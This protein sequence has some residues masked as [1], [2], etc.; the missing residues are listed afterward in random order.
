MA[1]TFAEVYGVRADAE[2]VVS[3]P[4]FGNLD[5]G[6]TPFEV[7]ELDGAAERETR[8]DEAAVSAEELIATR[9]RILREGSG[10]ELIAVIESNAVTWQD[11]LDAGLPHGDKRAELVMLYR[12]DCPVEFLR[13]SRFHLEVL[14]DP[15][16]P[17][18]TA[19][20]ILAAEPS[21]LEIEKLARRRDLARLELARAAVR[22]AKLANWR[23]RTG[24]L[25]L[26]LS[27]FPTRLLEELADIQEADAAGMLRHPRCPEDIVLKHI[28]SR[29]ANVRYLALAATEKRNL[30]IDSA[31]IRLAKQVPMTERPGTLFPQAERARKLADAILECPMNRAAAVSNHA[32][33][34]ST[35][36]EGIESDPR[37]IVYPMSEL[38]TETRPLRDEQVAYFRTTTGTRVHLPQCP[39]LHEADV[40]AASAAERLANP[41]CNWSRAQLGG[42]GREH[43]D[44]IEDAMRRVG[45]PVG[46]HRSSWRPSASWS[47]TR[48]SPST[49]SPTGPWAT[50]VARSPASARPTTGWVGAE[51]T[52]RRTST[53]PDPVT[54]TRRTTATSARSTTSPPGSTGPATTAEHRAA[55]KSTDGQPEP[56]KMGRESE[57]S[58]EPKCRQVVTRSRR[59]SD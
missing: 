36:A 41:V 33:S 26:R 27:T 14:T 12:D 56:G 54:P 24:S 2:W 48:S 46:A 22:G 37:T 17:V 38:T 34:G 49:A 25:F 1:R 39:H 6:L 9:M 57:S 13:K 29:S 7:L 42:F 47:S 5:A 55:A 10:A 11:L 45:V 20:A 18:G 3:P 50:R 28:L 15:A 52:C 21:A 8:D 58:G 32:E 51:R 59:W 43:F 4:E 44:G 35:Q 40:H 31:L 30:A 16:L 19:E 53:V 23:G